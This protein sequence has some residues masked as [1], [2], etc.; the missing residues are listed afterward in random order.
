M[1]EK[2]IAAGQQARLQY[3]Y[4]LPHDQQGFEWIKGEI[5]V[6]SPVRLEH[7][8]CSINLFELANARAQLH[9]PGMVGV[10]KMLIN[11]GPDY[12]FE[13]DLCFLIR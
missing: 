3:F 1:D 8:R 11:L 7:S 13:P 2:D 9:G 6:K 10:E 12:K 5:V 4:D